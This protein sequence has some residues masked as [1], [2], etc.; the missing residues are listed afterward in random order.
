M[1]SR[2]FSSKFQY[3]SGADCRCARRAIIA[4][5]R[6]QST[7][8]PDQPA[9]CPRWRRRQSQRPDHGRTVWR[10][11]IY[12]QHRQIQRHGCPIRG[13]SKCRRGNRHVRLVQPA[14]GDTGEQR[15]NRTQRFFWQL[16]LQPNRFAQ[17]A[18][19]VRKLGRHRAVRELAHQW[20][21]DWHAR[22]RHDR[23]RIVH[24]ERRDDRQCVR[25]GHP[26]RDSQVRYSHRERVVQGGI[27]RSDKRRN[28]LLA[29]SDADR[30]PALQ[31]DAAGQRCPKC[32][33]GG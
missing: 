3:L 27:L 21:A 9:V 10:R 1:A 2:R 19:C 28:Q 17:P 12:L 29:L 31:R 4:G 32:S 33:A 7:F 20:P 18:S 22:A 8:R 14:N 11:A 30:Q 25:R 6:I 16:C 23:D 13:V 5:R 26:Q 24:I 15:R